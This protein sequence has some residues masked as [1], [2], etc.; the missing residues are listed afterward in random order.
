MIT[1]PFGRYKGRDIQTV[2]RGYLRWMRENMELG[3]QFAH[4]V[5]CA[6]NKEP[7]D[8]G[9]VDLRTTEEKVEEIVKPWR[10]EIV[11]PWRG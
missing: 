2:P 8:L 1:M 5:K 11:K 7:V 6:I 4:A 9:A 10:E 3:P